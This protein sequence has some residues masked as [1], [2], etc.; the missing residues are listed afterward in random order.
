MTQTCHMLPRSMRRS[1][2][3]AAAWVRFWVTVWTRIVRLDVVITNTDTVPLTG[4]VIVVGD[5]RSMYDPLIWSIAIRRNGAM[6]ATWGL[7]F[8]PFIALAVILRGD[9]PVR[10]RSGTARRRVFEKAKAVLECGGAI[11]LFPDGRIV[12]SGVHEWRLGFARLALET[13]APIV[14]VS[15]ENLSY[16]WNWRKQIRVT[17]SP[18]VIYTEYSDM[19]EAEL[20]R[21]VMSLRSDSPGRQP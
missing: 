14:V 12:R 16:W 11:G 20:A 1:V 7:W 5:H 17:F 3:V 6:L 10:R 8:N 13:K 21:H 15:I 18:L 9:I 19:N 2:Y 4:P